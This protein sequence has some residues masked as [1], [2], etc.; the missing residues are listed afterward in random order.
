[1]EADNILVMDDGGM[2]GYGGHDKL[3]ADC[4]VYRQIY[5]AQF[6]EDGGERA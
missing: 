2:V 3:M 5:H 4:E 1:M 6:P